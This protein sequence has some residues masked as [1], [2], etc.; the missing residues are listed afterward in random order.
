MDDE[1]QKKEYI[2]R[3]KAVQGRLKSRFDSFTALTDPA[4]LAL[5]KQLTDQQ[6][7][8]DPEIEGLKST[9]NQRDL[10]IKFHW[11]HNHRFSEDFSVTGRMGNRHINLMA[12]FL[13]RYGLPDTHFEG[14]DVID[15]GCWT[16]GTTLLL[17]AMGAA[18][19]LALEEVQKYARTARILTQDVYEQDGISCEGTNLYDLETSKK[20]DIAYFPGVIYHLSDPVLALRRLF[21]ALKDGGE[22]LVE[23]AGLNDPRNICR[24]DGNRV[25]HDTEGEDV[26]KLNRGGWN[27]FLP[28]ASCLERWMIEAGFEDMDCFFSPATSRVFGYGRRRRH[29]EITRA[30]LSDRRIP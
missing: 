14:K 25:M 27:W 19:V 15:V 8:I 3:V 21:N 24:F 29:V 10:S 11:G 1:T 18:N 5:A 13:V 26:T 9:E 17:K 20:Y 6:G 2:E 7:T 12:Q 4:K 16:G 28:S 23:S 22:I 30:G